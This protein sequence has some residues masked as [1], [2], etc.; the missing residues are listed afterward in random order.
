MR[1]S[2]FLFLLTLSLFLIIPKTAFTEVV[3]CI[4]A[5]VN[6]DIITLTELEKAEQVLGGQPQNQASALH[7][8]GGKNTLRNEIL[9][10]LIDQKLA[11]QEAKKLG[12]SVSEAEVDKTI[13]K[14]VHDHGISKEQLTARVKEDGFTMEEYRQKLKQQIER[15]K[16]V[17]R[18]VNAKIVI[19]E[20]KLREYYQ[21]NQSRYL[22]Q[23]KYEVQHI[24]FGVAST[25]SAEEKQAI[26]KNAQ[27]VWRQAKEGEDFEGLARR[28]STY[29]TASEGGNLGLL[30]KNDL[31]PYMKEIIMTLKTGEIS[32]VVETPIGYQILKVAGI[33][34]LKTKTFEEVKEEIYEILFEQDVNRRFTAWIKELRDRSYIEVLI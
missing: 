20:D 19:T 16:L 8:Q 28:F 18:T 12:L 29:P 22:G 25:C 32:P 21:N 33:Q 4:V 2:R 30:D 7:M 11:E 3:D 17:S 31:A 23:Q 5:V 13:E 27:D 1:L 9:N 14:I 6:E 15:F 26:L 24:V 34:E 10:H